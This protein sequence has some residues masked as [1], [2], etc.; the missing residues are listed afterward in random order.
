M[1][2]GLNMQ[3]Q[4]LTVNFFWEIQEMNSRRV[5]AETYGRQN[6]WHPWH[7]RETV[8]IFSAI[9]LKHGHHTL[10]VYICN[11]SPGVVVFVWNR[12]QQQ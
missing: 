5:S 6:K 10:D 3:R 1:Y 9:R 4:F 2:V 8:R 7:K 11:A 12:A